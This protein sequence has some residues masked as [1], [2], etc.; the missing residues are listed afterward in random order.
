MIFSFCYGYLDTVRQFHQLVIEDSVSFSFFSDLS[1]N[2]C[3][4]GATR[5]KTS[6]SRSH[7]NRVP[8]PLWDLRLTPHKERWGEETLISFS[9]AY[10][11]SCKI[12]ITR[13]E[14][15][16]VV[17]F[18]VPSAISCRCKN[19]GDQSLLVRTVLHLRLRPLGLLLKSF[20][21]MDRLDHA[22]CMISAMMASTRKA[23]KNCNPVSI[24]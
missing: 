10:K 20:V 23:D 3:G 21:L 7:V 12:K 9:T 8:E 6:I 1:G 2:S 11:G 16:H 22:A 18:K 24:T 15:Q 14:R 5:A 17:S 19:P 13:P 4:W